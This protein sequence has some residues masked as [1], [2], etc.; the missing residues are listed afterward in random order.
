MAPSICEAF[1]VTDSPSG[2]GRGPTGNV[3]EGFFSFSSSKRV[4]P[5]PGRAQLTSD[6]S[7]RSASATGETKFSGGKMHS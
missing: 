1:G 3:N 5:S 7:F 2:G 6:K 4:S